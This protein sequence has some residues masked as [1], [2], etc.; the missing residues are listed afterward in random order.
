MHARADF[1]LVLG[2]EPAYGSSEEPPR[3]F[4]TALTALHS[5]DGEYIQQLPKHFYS[6]DAYTEK[7]IEYLSDR[8]K[9]D[10]D[11]P[12][13][14]Y[15]PFSAPHWPLQAPKASVD[16]YKSMYDDGP[17]ALRSRRLSSLI[18]KGL[19][20]TNVKPHKVVVTPGEQADWDTL[21]VE[22][23]GKSSRAMEI[24]AG[25]VDKMDENI[26]Y[27]I[28]HLKNTGEYENT[29]IIFMS[30]NGAEGASLEALPLFGH[31]VVDHVQKYYDNSLENMGR[32]DSFVWYGSRWAQAATAPSRLYKM[33][34][35]EG[36]CRVPFV[37]KPAGPQLACAGGIS[38]TFCTVMDLLPTLL[39]MASIKPHQGIFRGQPVQPLR[40]RSWAPSLQGLANT[41][42][43]LKSLKLHDDEHVTGWE[44]AGSGALR[45]GSYKITYVPAPKGPQ[46][47]EL[48]NIISDP[49]E[50]KD[51][52]SE[53]PDLLE[54]M[55]VLWE[56]YKS[57]VG[58][59]GLAGEFVRGGLPKD[60][61]EDT[62]K[63]I[64]HMAKGNYQSMP[65]AVK[66][67]L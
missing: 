22:E 40:G 4:E 16:K 51:L 7:M 49:G 33:F 61:F 38:D 42:T 32:H 20:P 27:V 53:Q 6:T 45:K 21:S 10:D 8:A 59:V 41:F 17:D 14:A 9:S 24:Y 23:R 60:E 1:V 67:A 46:R 54:A 19:V 50:T 63:W 56:Q 39:D 25:M 47:W 55:L 65:A 48:F 31:Q 44:I 43:D 5:Q 35:T 13:F 64:R 26:G 58:V 29:C 18:A 3:F 57:D 36:G 62:S 37:M 15:L 28:N 2:W 12:F 34:S 52:A 66:A 30:D 11:N